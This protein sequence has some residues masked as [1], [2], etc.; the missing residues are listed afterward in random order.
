MRCYLSKMRGFCEAA[1]NK[2][3]HVTPLQLERNSRAR[4]LLRSKIHT[5]VLL[6]S[7]R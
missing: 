2:M 7:F 5:A 6:R 1:K 4:G 3:T